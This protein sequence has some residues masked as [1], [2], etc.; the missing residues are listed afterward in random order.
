M[1]YQKYVSLTLLCQFN[2][3]YMIRITIFKSFY[4]RNI[5]NP[6]NTPWP[7]SSRK[8][9]FTPYSEYQILTNA[10]ILFTKNC[11]LF[12]IFFQIAHLNRSFHSVTNLHTILRYSCFRSIQHCLFFFLF[13]FISNT[14]QRKTQF[15]LNKVC[16]FI[17]AKSSL[18]NRLLDIAKT[19]F[20]KQLTSKSTVF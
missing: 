9:L 16:F 7:F 2:W 19:A 14:I 1:L 15:N 6:V 5:C 18:Y 10:I 12:H 8:P 17:H 4:I 3:L 20:Q 11:L 13:L